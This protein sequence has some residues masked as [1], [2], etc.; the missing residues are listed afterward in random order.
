MYYTPTK[1]I[2]TGATS[3]YSVVKISRDQGK[4]WKECKIPHSE[5]LVQPSVVRITGERY[6]MFLR[7]RYADW[8]YESISHNGCTW[9]IPKPTKLPNNNSSIQAVRLTDGHLVI[10]FNNINSTMIRGKPQTSPR[11][12]LSVALSEDNGKSWPWVRDL[13]TGRPG[14]NEDGHLS[15]AAGVD[16]YSYPSVIQNADGRLTVAYTF[17]REAIKTMSFD[18][19]WIKKGTSVGLFKGTAK[20]DG[21]LEKSRKLSQ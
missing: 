17:R 5:G 9:T 21:L 2:T 15:D 11:K 12:P 7:S 10:A 19:K 1:G 14:R 6:L 13:E 20:N 18:E 8:I 16:E 4:T 3:N